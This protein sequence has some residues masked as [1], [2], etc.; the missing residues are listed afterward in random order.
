MFEIGDYVQCIDNSG[1]PAAYHLTIGTVYKILNTRSD[2]RNGEL[3]ITFDDFR[4]WFAD[5]FTLVF[6]S[7]SNDPYSLDQVDV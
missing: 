1:T 6:K 5:R 2:P 7:V 3:L 4:W